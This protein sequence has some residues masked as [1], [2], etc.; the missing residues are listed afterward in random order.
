MLP[1]SLLLSEQEPQAF[2]QTPA[3]WQNPVIFHKGIQVSVP[4]LKHM[5]PWDHFIKSDGIQN[6]FH[7]RKMS[8]G[9]DRARKKMAFQP[10]DWRAS[11]L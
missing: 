7:M 6:Y 10:L 1:P 11:F 4:N 9:A 8:L 5:T 3:L 2:D